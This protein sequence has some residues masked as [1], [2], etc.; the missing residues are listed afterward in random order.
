MGFC[1]P[2][3]CT[4]GFGGYSRY[5]TL[6]RD[7]LNDFTAQA[8][9]Q[10]SETMLLSDFRVVNDSLVFRDDGIFSG[11]FEGAGAASSWELELPVPQQR[12]NY[13]LISDVRVTLYYEAFYDAQLDQW[14]RCRPIPKEDLQRNICFLLR[15]RFPDQVLCLSG[16]RNA[17]VGAVGY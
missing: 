4:G 9:L 10:L 2:G 13:G 8:R 1:R 3:E 7:E 14:V 17:R 5:W 6:E 11:I 16:A 12:L 15:P